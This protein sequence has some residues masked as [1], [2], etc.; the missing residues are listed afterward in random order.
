MPYLL[1]AFMA[2][3]DPKSHLSVGARAL[4]KHCH[5]ATVDSYWPANMNGTVDVRNDKALGVSPLSL[6]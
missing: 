5:R 6:T 1:P 2:A 3:F 4:C